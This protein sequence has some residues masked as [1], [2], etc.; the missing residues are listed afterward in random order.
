MGT[1]DTKAGT[2][3]K[4]RPIRVVWE[5]EVLRDPELARRQVEAIRA[6]LIAVRRNR[7]ALRASDTGIGDRVLARDAPSAGDR[8][9]GLLGPLEA[10]VVRQVWAARGAVDVRGILEGLNAGR[11]R[12]LG[13]TTVQATLARLAGKGVLARTRQGRRDLYASTVADAA[14]LAVRRLL[15]TFGEATVSPFVGACLGDPRLGA[16]LAREIEIRGGGAMARRAPVD[17]QQRYAPK[18]PAPDNCGF[19]S[20][21][22]RPAC[23]HRRSNVGDEGRVVFDEAY[24]SRSSRPLPAQAQGVE[25]VDAGPRGVLARSE[26]DG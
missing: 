13:Y 19:S 23:G 25:A 5:V 12:A 11:A 1:P 18:G 16:R 10:E 8:L 4:E 7:P 17:S 22:S 2:R 14:G 6:F 9:E 3:T 21:G 26:R 24:E 15:G 20:W